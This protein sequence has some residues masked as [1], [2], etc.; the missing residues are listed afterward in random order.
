MDKNVDRVP[1]EISMRIFL[2]ELEK[3]VSMNNAR[4]LLHSAA[5][6][7][8]MK[9]DFEQTMQKDQVEALCME[10]IRAGGP[11]FQAGRTIYNQFIS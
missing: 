6:K 8:G 7:S 2:T 5:I 3:K 1:A 9:P 10:L 4:L 11:G